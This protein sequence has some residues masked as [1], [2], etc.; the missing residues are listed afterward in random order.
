MFHKFTAQWELG[1]VYDI[2][3]GQGLQVFASVQ[4]HQIVHMCVHIFVYQ[5]CSIK[6]FL[7]EDEED[8]K[9]GRERGVGKEGR[10]EDGWQMDGCP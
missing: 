7:K 9:Q 6:L 5:S 3:C 10:K 2:D 4:T 1:C 8:K